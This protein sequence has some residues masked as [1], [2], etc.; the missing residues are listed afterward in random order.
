MSD[1]PV[2]QVIPDLNRALESHRRAV[3]SAP[4]GSGK[5]TLVPLELLDSSWLNGG[6]I[7]LL[8]P[9]RLAARAAASRM[10]S[11]LGE[12][13]GERVGYSIRLERKVSRKTRIEVVTEGILTR[14][15]QQNPELPG[16]GLVIFDEF[17]ERNLHSDLSL[18]LTL[19]AQQGLREDLH[20][21]VMSATLDQK[22]IS[23]LMD[24]APIVQALGRQFPVTCHYL[25]QI[26][27][28]RKIAEQVAGAIVRACQCE[29]GDVLAFLPGVAEIRS[30]GKLLGS[31]F[32]DYERVPLI[33]PLYGDLPK[34][35]QD[36]AILPDQ[37]KRRRIV[38]TTSIAET[39]LTIEGIKVVVD[40]GWSRMPRFLPGIGLTRLETVPVSQAAAVQRAGRAGRLGPGICYRICAESYHT[41]LQA[42]HPAEILQTDLAPLALQ[43]A[44]WGVADPMQLRW[45][46]PPPRGAFSQAIDL[47]QV[48]GALDEHGRITTLGRRMVELPTHPRLAHMLVHT[49]SE[50]RELVSDIVS[51][52]SERDIISSREEG[53]DLALRLR[54]LNAWREKRAPANATASSC[55]Y[56]DR[57]SK[58][59]LRRL[60][61][62][63]CHQQKQISVGQLLALAFPDRLAQRTGHARFRLVNGRAV[64]LA[65]HDP[66]A[67]EPFLV[68]AQLDAGQ[69][70]GR[71][72]LATSI[73]LE[74]IR[75]LPETRIN[76]L[77]E[78][79]WD[80]RLQRVSSSLEERLG[81]L[82]LSRKPLPSGDSEL[83]KAAMI[84]GIRI[85][86]LDALP[87]SRSVRQWQDRVIWL[88]SH[89]D[90]SN[91]PDLSDHW[92]IEHLETWLGPWL[93]SILNKEQLQ[94]LDLLTILQ[95]QLTWEQQ[96]S[97]NQWA[98]THLKVP[99][100]SKI[101]LQYTRDAGPVLA[102]RL[103]EM[104]GLAETPKICNKQVPVMLHL[105]SPAQRPIQI[106]DD[107]AGFWIRTYSEVKKELKGRYPKHYWPDDPLQAEATNRTKRRKS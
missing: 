82:V 107:L 32:S 86:G 79:L 49:S 48:L 26:P 60:Q 2:K 15:L 57:I 25:E 74:E 14:R 6:G 68:A 59:W 7:L 66:L 35:A 51:L 72:R 30:V 80:K 27:E 34:A 105:L 55:R 106:T 21:L 102:V 31:R 93:E 11:L 36:R 56:I 38:L 95:T 39:S 40:C 22:R 103:Q 90:D 91:W 37:K 9:R 4:P 78:I 18:A 50:K 44:S 41:Q 70:E 69:S 54:L 29:T 47:L 61:H 101:A 62:K 45:L 63:G 89:T 17:H 16:V 98:P 43:L 96:Q 58:D 10:A 3:L 53:C 19:D 5:T 28:K 83:I 73:D 97:L 94:R 87:W 76:H 99:S 84:D 24:D 71:V 23:A 92:L 81:A 1:L 42:H 65:E 52:L 64:R 33:T 100:G 67:N 85:M 75:S 20:L 46:D 104:F 13:V 8:E 12:S 88:G 77:Q